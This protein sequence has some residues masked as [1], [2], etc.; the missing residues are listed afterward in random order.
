MPIAGEMRSTM[1]FE[2]YHSESWRQRRKDIWFHLHCTW[3]LSWFMFSWVKGKKVHRFTLLLMLQFAF[4][5]MQFM[6]CWNLC[7]RRGAFC[8]ETHLEWAV[9]F[10]VDFAFEFQSSL[11]AL[12]VLQWLWKLSILEWWW[13][14]AEE[15]LG[16]S[17]FSCFPSRTPM[18]LGFGV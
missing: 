17:K 8:F 14:L 12:S 5:W 18:S 9:I 4:I 16:C 6:W 10:A 15:F 13:S 7:W 3:I 2:M 11:E 1:V